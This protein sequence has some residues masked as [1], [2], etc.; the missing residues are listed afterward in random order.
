[1]S[2]GVTTDEKQTSITNFEIV[3]CPD[4]GSNLWKKR[5]INSL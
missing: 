5:R 1:M 2:V 4:E 3:K